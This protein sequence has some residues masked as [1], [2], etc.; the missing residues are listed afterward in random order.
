VP[1]GVKLVGRLWTPSCQTVAAEADAAPKASKLETTATTPQRRIQ[2]GTAV[3]VPLDPIFP[4]TRSVPFDA[5]PVPPTRLEG[6]LGNRGGA[7]GAVHGLATLQ[8]PTEVSLIVGVPRK[9]KLMR[10]IGKTAL[11]KPAGAGQPAER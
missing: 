1:P 9:A 3:E 8:L 2:A 4:Q 10:A 5:V 7:V 11:G 6:S